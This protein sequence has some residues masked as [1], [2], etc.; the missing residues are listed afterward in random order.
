[1]DFTVPAT[2]WLKILFLKF[3]F[4]IIHKNMQRYTSERFKSFLWIFSIFGFP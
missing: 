2:H 4:K 1:M 3:T